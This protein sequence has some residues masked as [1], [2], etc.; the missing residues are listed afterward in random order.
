MFGQPN[1]T[2]IRGRVD[3]HPGDRMN[4]DSA[5]MCSGNRETSSRHDTQVTARR[6]ADRSR[7][8]SGNRAAERFDADRCMFGK[9]D[10]HR[11]GSMRVRATVRAPNSTSSGDRAKSS[12]HRVQVTARREAPVELRLAQ[13]RCDATRSAWLEGDFASSGT[14][15]IIA[16]Q[17]AVIRLDHPRRLGNRMTAENPDRRSFGKPGA[18]RSRERWARHLGDWMRSKSRRNWLARLG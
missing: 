17:L 4:V 6:A 2:P 3:I 15:W 11:F 5:S 8:S 13:T 12:R 9:P 18:R 10:E 14:G 16:G 1:A 7:R